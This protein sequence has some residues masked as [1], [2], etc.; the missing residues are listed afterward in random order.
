MVTREEAIRRAGELT[1]QMHIHRDSLSGADAAREAD[2]PTGPS[3]AQLEID[4]RA[5]R[6]RRTREAS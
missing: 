6:A 2:T 4:I 3:I 5:D 1:A